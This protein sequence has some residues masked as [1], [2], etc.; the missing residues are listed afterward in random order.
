MTKLIVAF[1]N[2]VNASKKLNEVTEM[3]LRVLFNAL[4]T[5]EEANVKE[6]WLRE[7]FTERTLIIKLS[8]T[9]CA[10]PTLCISWSAY[11]IV[12]YQE[13]QVHLFCNES[14]GK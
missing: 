6:N 2:F 13:A 7:R 10:L 11:C 8:D 5:M 14:L 3:C 9:R 12:R 1:R 4:P